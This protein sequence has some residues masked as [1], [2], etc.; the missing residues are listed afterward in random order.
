MHKPMH[1]KLDLIL[2]QTTKTNG[3]LATHEVRISKI[4]PRLTL[5]QRIVFGAVAVILLAFM[6]LMTDMALEKSS[7]D[8]ATAQEIVRILEAKQLVID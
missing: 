4:E 3:K 5:V 6:A 8:Q 2:E 1:E 7:S